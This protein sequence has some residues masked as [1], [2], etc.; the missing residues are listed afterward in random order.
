MKGR[1]FE[2]LII[3]K[4]KLALMPTWIWSLLTV[5]AVRILIGV[6]LRLVKGKPARS[7][8]E[9]LAEQRRQ[10]LRSQ[11]A[12]PADQPDLPIA[13]GD[14]CGWFCV[15]TTEGRKVAA[16]FGLKGVR[17]SNWYKG[18][19][20]AFTDQFFVTPAVDGWTMVLGVELPDAET[21]E[22]K[23]KIQALL[24]RLS[25]SYGEA[26][27]FAC[28]LPVGLEC[29]MKARDG[30]LIRAYAEEDNKVLFD[31]G[32]REENEERAATPTASSMAQLWSV[33]PEKLEERKDLEPG[34]GWTGTKNRGVEDEGAAGA[35]RLG[36]GGEG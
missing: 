17:R 30:T 27:Y 6:I 26:Q 10:R 1:K 34:L 16:S 12:V 3:L 23:R 25:K 20:A 22:G 13:F 36:V 31:E 2:I 21:E 32:Q 28:F 29:W 33:N 4:P 19:D 15:R 5:I 35:A 8:Q 7:L 24:R 14:K 11:A 18:F 9:E